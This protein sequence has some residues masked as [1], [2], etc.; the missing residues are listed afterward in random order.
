MLLWL[1][2][3][4]SKQFNLSVCSASID[5]VLKYFYRLILSLPAAGVL[6]A[7][8][9]LLATAEIKRIAKN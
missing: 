5:V 1:R 4:Q 6:A 9:V 2:A 3:A 7:A 8:L